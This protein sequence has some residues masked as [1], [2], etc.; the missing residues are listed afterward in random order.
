MKQW[1]VNFFNDHIT[2]SKH[3][4]YSRVQLVIKEEE[5][6]KKL[7]S[8]KRAWLPFAYRFRKLMEDKLRV[9]R[10]TAFNVLNE[11]CSEQFVTCILG[12]TI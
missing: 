3:Y 11:K 2:T 6:C 1:K 12:G 9:Y 10:S 8:L 5:Y 7:G 4:T